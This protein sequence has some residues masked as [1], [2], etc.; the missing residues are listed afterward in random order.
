MA[1]VK[2]NAIEVAP[3]RAE[4]ANG[5]CGIS[6]RADSTGGRGTRFFVYTRWA[7]EAEYRSGRDSRAFPRGH[8]QARADSGESASAAPTSPVAQGSSLLEFE[9]VQEVVKA[10]PGT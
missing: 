3:G 5:R 9:V 2:I 7:S 4:S 10:R 6:V 8:A 1:A